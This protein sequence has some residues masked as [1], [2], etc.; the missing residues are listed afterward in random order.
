MSERI[1]VVEDEASLRETLV[2]NLER[3]GYQVDFASDGNDAVR[4]ARQA[5]PDLILLDIMLPG[6][7]GFEVCRILRREMTAPIIFLTAKDEE[8]DRIIG[9][10][11]GGDDYILKPFSMRELFARLKANFR[12]IRLIRQEAEVQEEKPEEERVLK[13]YGDLT[14]DEKRHE[15]SVN[16]IPIPHKP[17]EYELL[18]FFTEHLG[19]ML[20]RE[21]ILKEVWGYDF[22]GDSRTIDVHVRWLREKIEKNPSIPTRIVT[23]RGGGYRFEG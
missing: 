21:Q 13:V 9:L 10:E 19:R 17:K 20:T 5:K 15:I 6:I 7:D 18:L 3:Q 8:I 14:I 1:L 12:R 2:Y 4:A 23:V 11:I 22:I 16:G